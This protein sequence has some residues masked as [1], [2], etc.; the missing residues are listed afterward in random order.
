MGGFKGKGLGGV[1]SRNVVG[2]LCLAP[3][4]SPGLP[5]GGAFT[6]RPWALATCH[7]RGPQGLL[8]C[9]CLL[10]A[11]P[12]SRRCTMCIDPCPFLT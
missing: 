8:K 7:Q 2:D 12:D 6:C 3:Q 9:C 10:G 1:C 5:W 4:R 11:F